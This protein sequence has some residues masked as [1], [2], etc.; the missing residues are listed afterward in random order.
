MSRERLEALRKKKRLAEL[1]AKQGEQPTINTPVVEEKEKDLD[2]SQAD[3]ILRGAGQGATLELLDEA[4]TVVGIELVRFQLTLETPFLR[5]PEILE[6]ISPFLF[7]TTSITWF[8]CSAFSLSNASHPG[9]GISASFLA[10][11]DFFLLDFI[12][13]GAALT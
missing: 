7:F 8:F 2:V 12:D 6:T 10:L 5:G 11:S 9:N 3:A 4:L 13:S 1:R